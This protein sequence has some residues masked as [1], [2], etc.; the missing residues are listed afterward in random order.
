[1]FT[2]C[3]VGRPFGRI[4]MQIACLRLDCRAFYH[5]WRAHGGDVEDGCVPQEQSD[6]E[7]SLGWL[8]HLEMRAFALRDK[9]K[10]RQTFEDV[11]QGPGRLQL[12]ADREALSLLIRRIERIKPIGGPD[13]KKFN[14]KLDELKGAFGRLT[15]PEQRYGIGTRAE[16]PH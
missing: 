4:R 15:K 12:I 6:R 9:I 3:G 7:D 16:S 13:A 5:D 14:E 8:E 2:L 11:T 1:M 10:V